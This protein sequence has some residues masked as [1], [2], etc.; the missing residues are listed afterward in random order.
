MLCSKTSSFD[1]TLLFFIRPASDTVLLFFQ[2]Y[3]LFTTTCLIH[4][5]LFSENWRHQLARK[6]SRQHTKLLQDFETDSFF[7]NDTFFCP[8]LVFYS[9]Q[10]M[11]PAYL[12]HV[13]QFLTRAYN[14]QTIQTTSHTSLLPNLLPKKQFAFFIH[15]SLWQQ[16]AFF[17]QPEIRKNKRKKLMQ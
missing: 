3:Q 16:L 12:F 1:T 4:R 5:K 13:C 17:K 8:H 11:I 10:F 9:Y 2:K 6:S 7:S 14:F 15:M